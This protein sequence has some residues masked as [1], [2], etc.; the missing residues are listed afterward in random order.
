MADAS[1]E[2]DDDKDRVNQVKHGVSFEPAQRAFLDSRRVMCP[3]SAIAAK[4]SA[5]SALEA[6]K[7]A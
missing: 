1:F 3:T 4:S 7:A 2:W 6:W 5:I